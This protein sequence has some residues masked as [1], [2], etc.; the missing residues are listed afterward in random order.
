MEKIQH[1]IWCE[2]FGCGKEL[3]N[4][5]ILFI[6]RHLVTSGVWTDLCVMCVV[7]MWASLH[8]LWRALCLQSVWLQNPPQTHTAA[9]LHHMT[10][11]NKSD[12]VHDQ[13]N[14][15]FSWAALFLAYRVCARKWPKLD[16]VT[17]NT[18]FIDQL[19]TSRYPIQR[20]HGALTDHV[21]P[22]TNTHTHTQM[23]HSGCLLFTQLYLCC[24]SQSPS[25]LSYTRSL[26]FSQNKLVFQRCA[27]SL[28]FHSFSPA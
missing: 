8:R 19:S 6:L 22:G 9:I 15:A 24:I 17:P 4:W 14:S 26:F 7:C 12:T 1:R 13:T 11:T 20:K 16:T 23:R 28:S 27:V 18:L 21:T 10:A 25:S 3:Y 5:P 2:L